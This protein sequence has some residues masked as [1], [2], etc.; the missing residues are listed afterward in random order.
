MTEHLEF[1]H[2]KGASRSKW[3]AG[4]LVVMLVGWMGS[5]YVLPAA[6]APAEEATPAKA[7]R[8]AV[9]VAVHESHAAPVQQEFLAEGQA[10]PRRDTALRAETGG[11]VAEIVIEKGADVES[12]AVIARIDPA[13]RQADLERARS[14]VTRTA[15]DLANARTLLARGVATND[16]LIESESAAAAARAGLVAAE[17]AMKNLE[18][19]AP[20]SG[21]IESL[22]LQPGELIGAGSEIGR[23]VDLNPLTVSVQVPQQSIADVKVG[24]AAD[25]HFITGTDRAGEVT[26]VGTSADAQT[27]TFTAEITV[28]NEDGT[29]PAGLSAQVR[30]PTGELEAHFL[31]PAIL[32]LDTTGQLGVKAVGEGNEVV[33]YPVEILRAQTD[34]IWVGGLPDALTVITVGQGFVNRGEIVEPKASDLL[35]AAAQTKADTSETK[36]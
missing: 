22:D 4:L 28:P 6:E 31:S 13:Q 30:I 5:G 21:R 16:R 27:R 3:I 19:V 32:S 36:E 8:R 9:T 34:G 2:E 17:E 1:Q 24:M 15:R 11:T 29:I 20:F 26:F 18:I 12:G 35:E 14:E 33:F 23:I 7:E 25:V 10:E